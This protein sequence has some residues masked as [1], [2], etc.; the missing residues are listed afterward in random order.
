[1]SRL[2]AR[3][4]VEALIRPL[5]A[6]E[7]ACLRCTLSRCFEQHASCAYRQAMRA[8]DLERR[9]GPTVGRAVIAEERAGER[10]LARA[11]AVVR[12]ETGTT[13]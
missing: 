1:M 10:R 6:A 5:T 3:N 8:A 12:A 2:N 4:S 11:L 7:S 9:G 13:G